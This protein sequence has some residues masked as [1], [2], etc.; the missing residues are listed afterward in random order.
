MVLIK[1]KMTKLS[2]S[3]DRGNFHIECE[4]KKVEEGRKT[5]E[6]AQEMIDLY[7]S[8]QDQDIEKEADPSAPLIIPLLIPNG[9]DW[10]SFLLPRS[11][12]FDDVG[13]NTFVSIFEFPGVDESSGSTD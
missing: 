1:Q 5:M 13:T 10:N 11:L 12:N 8:W 3:P 7:Q 9:R 4:L 2:T 6:Q